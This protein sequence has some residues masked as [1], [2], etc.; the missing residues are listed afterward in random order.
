MAK[1]GGGLPKKGR[2]A[3]VGLGPGIRHFRGQ[4]LPRALGFGG[5]VLSEN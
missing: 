2:Y 3:F 1:G 5:S 4:F